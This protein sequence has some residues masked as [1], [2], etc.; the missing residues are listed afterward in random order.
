MDFPRKCRYLELQSNVLCELFSE[1]A[2]SLL[3]EY[4]AIRTLNPIEN[5]R[6]NF[7]RVSV[8]NRLHVLLREA[9]ES[10]YA[11]LSVFHEIGREVWNYREEISFVYNVSDISSTH[12]HSR[13]GAC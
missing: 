1:N 11:L 8:P 7:Q 4:L 3:E 13:Q 10:V 2:S 6:K 5:S 9:F 12:N